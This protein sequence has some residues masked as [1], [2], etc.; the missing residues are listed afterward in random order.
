MYLKLS[1]ETISTLLHVG[2]VPFLI[3][4]PDYYDLGFS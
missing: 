2:E 4:K 3:L 1:Q